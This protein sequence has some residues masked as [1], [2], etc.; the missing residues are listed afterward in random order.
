[1]TST[2]NSGRANAVTPT[3]VLAGAFVP[4]YRNRISRNVCMCD[5]SVTCI[6]FFTMLL[7]LAPT[8]VS[9]SFKLLEHLLRPGQ[10][11]WTDQLFGTAEGQHDR[12]TQG[13]NEFRCA[14]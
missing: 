8:A 4:Q 10:S 2:M 14:Q 3:S 5:M 11:V 7:K 1:M 12:T 13:N 9:A 6:L